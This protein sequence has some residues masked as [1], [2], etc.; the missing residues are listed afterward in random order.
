MTQSSKPNLTTQLIK[1]FFFFFKKL[2]YFIYFIFGCVGSSL[3]CMGFLQ[4][5]RAGA[6]LCFGVRVSHCGG[7]SC[8]GAQAL[9]AW[10]SVFVACGLSGVARGLQSVGS[11]VWLAGCRAQAQQLWHM[12][13]A[14]P[15][16]VGSSQP[17]AQTHVPCIGRRILNHCATREAPK[18]VLQSL[19]EKLK[20]F[21]QTSVP[22]CRF[23]RSP[24]HREAMPSI[25]SKLA[26]FLVLLRDLSWAPSFLS[27]SMVTFSLGKL[28]HLYG[29]NYHLFVHISNS[30]IFRFSVLSHNLQ[31]VRDISTC[32]FIHLTP[33]S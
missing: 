21:L 7:F 20:M 8:C 19:S 12:G 26:T 18:Q 14:A 3:L 5:R 6:T 1:F 4:L 10:A 23:V 33:F 2:I 16:H 28:T 11:A 25:P 17:R 9:G 22:C 13:L 31:T 24:L 30:H 32:F 29:N 15:R 27:H